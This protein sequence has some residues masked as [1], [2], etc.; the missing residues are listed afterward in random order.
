MKTERP[1]S[2]NFLS[3]RPPLTGTLTPRTFPL[4]A[5]SGDLGF[6][7]TPPYLTAAFALFVFSVPF[8]AMALH[9]FKEIK[10]GLP[11]VY[12]TLPLLI[13][14]AAL[15][16][17]KLVWPKPI[18]YLIGFGLLTVSSILQC[19]SVRRDFIHLSDRKLWSFSATQSAYVVATV[20]ATIV[21]FQCVASYPNLLRTALRAQ[22]LAVIFACLWGLYQFFGYMFG[23]EYPLVFNNNLYYAQLYYQTLGA[24]NRIS[25]IA[26]EPSMF[27]IYLATV[28]P[29]YVYC[30]LYSLRI[31]SR[32]LDTLVLLL[33]GITLF[34]TLSNT[35]ILGIIT[36]SLLMIGRKTKSWFHLA[37]ILITVSLLGCAVLLYFSPNVARLTE[38]SALLDRLANV[39]QGTD[40]SAN[41]RYNSMVMGARVFIEHPILGVGEGNA[42]YYLFS[43][44]TRLP[45]GM[46]PRV[47][48][49]AVRTLA[50]HG[51]V[52]VFLL[53]SFLILTIRHRRPDSL[54][55]QVKLAVEALR[56]SVIVS[57]FLMIASMTEFAHYE[58]WTASALLLGVTQWHLLHPAS[59]KVPPPERK[60][61]PMGGH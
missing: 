14:A 40:A 60:L 21:V 50:E 43:Y 7:R 54:S 56:L 22:T 6:R 57:F 51:L 13:L 36:L 15:S 52:G 44:D 10:F 9:D 19:M 12:V 61:A 3:R 5:R 34:L 47:L 24:F 59:H 1:N 42:G 20:I 55:K 18:R 4:P 37:A 49:L 26:M 58:A 48:S 11:P 41:D 2:F 29:I 46:Q 17:P 8:K 35:A 25:S 31:F 33:C 39:I 30:C 16:K 23:W 27:A 53:G 32:V 28:L 45:I 38:G